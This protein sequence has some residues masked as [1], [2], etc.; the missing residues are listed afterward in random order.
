M[1]AGL[2]GAWEDDRASLHR[3][4]IVKCR[5]HTNR[6]WLMIPPDRFAQP[7]ETHEAAVA[8]LQAWLDRQ[9]ATFLGAP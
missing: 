1:M 6:C 8:L 7:A 2:Y 3:P 9:T 4:L 5:V